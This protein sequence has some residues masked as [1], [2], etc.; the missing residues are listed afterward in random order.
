MN[1]TVT[2][3]EIL[4]VTT[5]AEYEDDVN[6]IMGQEYGF[7]ALPDFDRHPRNHRARVCALFPAALDGVPGGQ[8]PDPYLLGNLGA[9]GYTFSNHE[10][11]ESKAERQAYL[12]EITL[13]EFN[14]DVPTTT[15][16]NSEGFQ[17]TQVASAHYLK[18]LGEHF[19][20]DTGR[21]VFAD[22]L[23][24]DVSAGFLGPDA[25]KRLH[26]AYAARPL[27]DSMKTNHPLQGLH[28]GFGTVFAHAARHETGCVSFA[29]GS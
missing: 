4:N 9:H 22:L 5:D 10:S 26:T 7:L 8:E 16:N 21:Q 12:A 17:T 14:F 23:D 1:I 13:D 15:Y 11:E 19:D 3:H 28:E 20:H 25:C 18:A 2:S 6:E 24:F 29:S 27:L